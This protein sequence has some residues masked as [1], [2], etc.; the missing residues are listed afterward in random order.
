MHDNVAKIKAVFNKYQDIVL[1]SIDEE[2]SDITILFSYKNICFMMCV[3]NYTDIF[4]RRITVFAFPEI[5]NVGIPPHFLKMEDTEEMY[6]LCLLEK[7]QHVL[8]A[9]HLFELIELYLEQVKNLLDMN[10]KQIEKEFQKEFLYYWNLSVQKKILMDI[11][12]DEESNVAELELWSERIKNIEKITTLPNNLSLN[13]CHKPKGT[14]ETAL[15]IPITDISGI[16]PP[17]GDFMW[18]QKELLNIVCNHVS[19]KISDSTYR[20]LKQVKIGSYRKIVVLSFK[21]KDSIT[22]CFSAIITFNTNKK[23]TFINKLQDD[24]CSIEPIYSQRMDLSFLQSRVGMPI[25]LHLPSVLVLGVGSVGSYIVPELVN[26][27]INNIGLSDPDTFSS[28]NALRHYLGPVNKGKNKA[29]A[30]KNTVEKDNPL[31]NISI[32]PNILGME[33]EEL[34]STITPYDIIIVAVGT[35]DIQREMNAKFSKL[36]LEKQYIFNWLDSAGKGAHLLFTNYK[37]KG[38]FNCLFFDNGHKR[39]SNKTSFA[40][41]TETLIGNG[42]C[43]SFSPYGNN[44]LLRNTL[45]VISV[46]KDI[47]DKK[48][49]ENILV[50]IQNNFDS[51]RDSLSIEPVINKDFY[52]KG[53]DICGSL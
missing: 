22:I 27:G 7:E 34:K 30:M 40:D 2:K 14:Y 23:D 19:D 43:G 25:N 29:I 3:I 28:G 53:C 48:I 10:S 31:V 20:F 16:L 36:N 1:K 49:N 44:V 6:K 47:I 26:L 24:F 52:D 45:M 17:N 18:S 33:I 5:N 4:M 39:D 11:Y 13:E 42:C 12:I 50:S 8:T 15:Y 41:G 46:I 21:L 32:I 9:Y 38:C 37:T 51:F 35:S